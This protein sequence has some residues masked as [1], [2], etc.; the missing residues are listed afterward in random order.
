MGNNV[1]ISESDYTCTNWVLEK[2]TIIENVIHDIE[3]EFGNITQET[4]QEP[5]DYYKIKNNIINDKY[6]TSINNNLLLSNY[7]SN[8]SLFILN[9]NDDDSYT[10]T[11]K[12]GK[13]YI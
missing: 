8:Y 6:L 12:D 4:I 13:T 10:I 2:V 5:V 1:V 7:D 11:N 9:K 3:D